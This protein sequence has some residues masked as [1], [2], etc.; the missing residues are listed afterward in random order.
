MRLA[1]RLRVEREAAE[2]SQE[3]LALLVSEAIEGPGSA[4]LKEHVV[5]CVEVGEMTMP[6]EFIPYIARVLG[7]TVPR[8]LGEIVPSKESQPVNINTDARSAA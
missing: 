6:W 5:R 4:V 7:V 1:K 3:R 2:M 8:L